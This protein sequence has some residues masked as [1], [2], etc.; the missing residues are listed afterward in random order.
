MFTLF[1]VSFGSFFAQYIENWLLQSLY[2]S[3]FR[4]FQVEND[5]LI[6]S[7]FQPATRHKERLLRT[8]FPKTPHRM[9]VHP[10]HTFAPGTHI[11]ER[12]IRFRKF[13][14]RFIVSGH[15]LL[16]TRNVLLIARKSI[17]DRQIIHL[18]ILYYLLITVRSRQHHTLRDTFT[19]V[20]GLIEINTSHSFYQ[21]I[22]LGTLFQSR[23]CNGKFSFPAIQTRQQGIVGKDLRPVVHFGDFEHCSGFY[24]LWQNSAVEDTSPTL[25]ELFH[26]LNIYCLF[27]YGQIAE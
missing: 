17:I 18:P 16:A 24:I 13:E 11:E 3:F 19:V 6:H 4:T 14:S 7:L 26:R 2:H 9:A 8:D 20:N 23:Q 22:K 25:I 21:N 10:H 15:R 12:I 5:N 1:A 27:C